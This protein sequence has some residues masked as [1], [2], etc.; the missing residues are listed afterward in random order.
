MENI[1]KRLLPQNVSMLCGYI[2]RNRAKFSN[3]LFAFNIVGII[4][5]KNEK[6]NGN[7]RKKVQFLQYL[8]L[9][10]TAFTF[11][12]ISFYFPYQIYFS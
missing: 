11:K 12:T 10:Q 8:S 6:Q 1:E 5:A 4:L 7:E 2:G 9:T 3:A